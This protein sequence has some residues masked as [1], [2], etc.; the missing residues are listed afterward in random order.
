[1]TKIVTINNAKEWSEAVDALVH[2]NLFMKTYLK[3]TPFD[4]ADEELYE[5]L[6]ELI[7]KEEDDT[8]A[9]IELDYLYCCFGYKSSIDEN[10]QE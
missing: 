2:Q 9:F 10:P 4:E 1:M 8:D 5:I 7:F 6:A 3:T